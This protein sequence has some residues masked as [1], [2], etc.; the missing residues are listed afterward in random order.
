MELMKYQHVQF[1]VLLEHLQILIQKL[2]VMLRKKL[3]LKAEPISTQII[4]RDRHAH[5]TFQS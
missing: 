1:L 4:P 3:K 2:K 5:S